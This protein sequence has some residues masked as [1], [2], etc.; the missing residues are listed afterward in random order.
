MAL[1]DYIKFVHGTPIVF[2]NTATHA[3]GASA[4]NNLGVATNQINLTSVTTNAGRQS[5]KVDLGANWARQIDVVAALEFAA[6]PTAGNPV[7][8]WWAPSPSATAGQAMPGNTTGA[9]AAYAGYSSNLDDSAN[10]LQFI[11]NFICTAQ[12]TGTIQ[13]SYV[14]SF[15][16]KFQYGSLVIKNASGASLHSDAVEMSVALFPVLDSQQDT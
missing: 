16:P 14:G 2:A 9:D 3:P 11:G 4:A 10:H 5:D 1:P 13:V 8:L 6:T 15:V 12:A 7:S